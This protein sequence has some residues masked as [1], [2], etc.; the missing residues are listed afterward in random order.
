MK[1]PGIFWDH[2]KHRDFL[3]LYFYQ[4]KSTI[5]AYCLCGI[6]KYFCYFLYSFIFETN[7]NNLLN[8]LY[9]NTEGFVGYV[10]KIL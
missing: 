2:K 10:K 6:G 1:D 3:V 9:K 8:N 5:T 4:L 7:D